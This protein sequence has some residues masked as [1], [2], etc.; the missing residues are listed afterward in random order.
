MPYFGGKQA[1]AADIVDLFPAHEMYVEPFAGGLSVL[2]AKPQED[3]EVVNDL[4]GDLVNFWRVLRESPVE[5]IEACEMTPHARAEFEASED[6]TEGSDVERARRV[7]VRLTQGRS[8]H[9]LKTGWRFHTSAATAPGLSLPSYLAAYRRRLDPVVHRLQN[10]TLECM[11]ALECIERYGAHGTLLYVDPPYLGET[12]NSTGYQHEMLAETQHVELLEALLGTKADVV[13]SGYS[14]PL[15]EEM[16]GS[17]HRSE[18]SARTQE[19]KART[20]VVWASREYQP[21]L[22]ALAGGVS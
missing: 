13:V 16:L 3:L 6:V 1:T 5:L 15:Y 2:L 19:G 11:P 21:A 22:F 18:I 12:R 4:D 8:A 9:L 17:W 14:S 20:E 7:W 10:V